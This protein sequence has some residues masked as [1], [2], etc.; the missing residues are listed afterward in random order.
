MPKILEHPV[1]T[2][3][4][5]E[6]HGGTLYRYDGTPVDG[7][8]IEQIVNVPVSEWKVVGEVASLFEWQDPD[9]ELPNALRCY[10][11]MRVTPRKRRN[12]QATFYAGG[13][14][15]YGQAWASE[16]DHE[17]VIERVYAGRNEVRGRAA[18]L[19][20]VEW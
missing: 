8:V 11:L 17:L 19:G 10:G 3:L 16:N 14:I 13:G 6:G 1:T 7:H 4:F 2:E 9:A 15:R 18:S 12:G 20:G 5:L